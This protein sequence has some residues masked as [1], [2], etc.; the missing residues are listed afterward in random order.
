MHSV[1]LHIQQETLR[2]LFYY[3]EE[4][5]WY[6]MMNDLLEVSIYISW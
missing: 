2:T 5:Q 1:L 3:L 6:V 4:R